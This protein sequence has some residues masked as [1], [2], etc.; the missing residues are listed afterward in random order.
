MRGLNSNDPRL[1]LF[2]DGERFRGRNTLEY[3]LLDPAEI[4]RI[5]IVR[6]PASALYG[7]D[8]MAGVVNVITRR[9]IGDPF[10]PLRLT[11]RIASLGYASANDFFGGRVELE[12]LGNGFDGLVGL[13]YR[14]AGDYRSP[15]GDIPNSDFDTRAAT[16]RLGF[17]PDADRRFEFIGRLNRVES[18]RAGGIAGAPGAPLL[19]VR[20]DPLEENFVRLGYTQRRVASWLDGLETT[21]YR[22]E[23][24]TTITTEDRT[25]A[26]GNVALRNQYVVGPVVYGGKAIGRSAMGQTLLTYGADFYHEERPGSENDARTLNAAGTQIAVTPRA[27]RN[28]AA[29][30]LNVGAFLNADWDPSPMWTLS[31]AGRYDFVRTEVEATPAVGENAALTNAFARNQRSDDDAVTGAGGIVFRAWPALHL[32]ANIATAFRAPATFEKYSGSVAGAVTSI[33][34]PDLKPERSTSYEAGFRVRLPT[35]TM[36]VTAFRSDYDDLIQLAVVNAATRQRRNVGTAEFTGVELDGAYAIARTWTLR[37][38]ASQ[39]RGTNAQTGQP[40]PY[41]PPLNGFVSVR[42]APASYYVESGMR[43]YSAKTRIDP[44]QERPTGGYAT[45]NL[46]A[47]TGLGALAPALK[48][49]RLAVGIENLFGKQYV[50]PVTQ[51]NVA[52]PPS[53]TNPL[54]EPGRSFVVNIAGAL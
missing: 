20:E 26:N 8:A 17:S 13:N 2:V 10:Q 22:R 41:I 29:T 42:Y 47:G 9:A 16:A 50:N 33:P 21:L 24:D 35:F 39:V 43:A 51:A 38:N 49:Y 32:V 45:F 37:F 4:E 27:K 48:G 54:I 6:G 12:G 52:F 23:L 15:A 7:S 46:Y 44:S 30:Q 18:G 5:E 53:I 28:R 36:N 25:A 11:P 1:V 19:R 34:N 40:L 31:A 14:S 3:N